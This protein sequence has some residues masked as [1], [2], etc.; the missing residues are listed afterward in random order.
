MITA[1]GSPSSASSISS[2]AARSTTSSLRPCGTSTSRRPWLRPRSRTG[3]GRGSSSI[4]V[5][6]SRTAVNS[7]SPPP[8]PNSSAPAS[9]WSP[10]PTTSVTSRSSASIA[11]TPLYGARV[12]ILAAEHADPEKGTGILMV[13]TFGDAM[14]VE[15]WKTVGSGAQTAHRPRWPASCPR[16]SGAAPFESVDAAAAQRA[17]DEIA[18]T[19]R[20]QGED[21]DR[22]TARRGRQSSRVGRRRPRRRTQTHR[23]DG[24]VLREGRS[25][26][27]V[28][29]H[30]T[31]VR[32]DPRAQR[33]APRPGR[34]DP[35]APGAHEDPLLPLGR[36]S[37]PGLVHLAPTLLRGSVPGLVRRSGRMANRTSHSRSTPTRRASRSI[38]SPTPRPDTPT[39]SAMSPVGSP[40]SPMSW[41]PGRPRR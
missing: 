8:G 14:D 17:H 33:G 22:R 4:S 23:S 9:P 34:Q 28:R 2:S 5:S 15:W 30:P 37:Q 18:G 38:L 7:S 24:Q 29:A 10:T 16:P 1:G 3:R 41:T 6:G 32:Q 26:A 20:Q 13:C 39:I 19:L 35:V 31:V 25:S 11:I 40:P 21:E 27:R 36:G 12:P